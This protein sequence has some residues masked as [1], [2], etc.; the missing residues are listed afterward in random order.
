MRIY[1]LITRKTYESEM[2]LRASKKLG[3][4]HAVLTKLEEGKTV[5]LPC[6][7]TDAMLL[8]CCRY[9]QAGEE[10]A[11]PADRRGAQE[12]CLW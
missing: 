6:C 10:D 11:G 5:A 12:R 9:I 1:R 4:D 7:S 2:F 8:C 3:L